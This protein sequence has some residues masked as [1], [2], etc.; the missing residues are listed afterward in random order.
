MTLEMKTMKAVPRWRR[1]WWMRVRTVLSG[2]YVPLPT[3]GIQ[4]DG[5]GM[6][7]VVERQLYAPLQLSEFY[8]PWWAWPFELIHRSIFGCVKV[9]PSLPAVEAN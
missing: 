5:F 1:K 4:I 8:V 2:P 9:L 7:P 3:R 6:P